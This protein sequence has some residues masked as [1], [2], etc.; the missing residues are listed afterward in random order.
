MTVSSDFYTYVQDIRPFGGGSPVAYV[1]DTSL[2]SSN[3]GTPLYQGE[4]LA[5]KISGNSATVLRFTRNGSAGD[6]VG[7]SRDSMQGV[8]KLGNQSALLQSVQLEFSVFTTGVHQMLGTVGETYS[9]GQ[10]VYMGADTATI[11]NV[12]GTGGVTI[13]IVWL[14][15]NSTKVGA[16]RVPIIIDN[17]TLAQS[18]T[19]T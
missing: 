9:H 13:G 18:G 17:H 7:I 12:Q 3:G 5:L 1:P 8:A 15:D 11:T 16:V 2:Y 6:F 19:G 10:S 14:P 4:L